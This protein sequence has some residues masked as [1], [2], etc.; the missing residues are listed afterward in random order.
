MPVLSP[1]GMLSDRK[2]PDPKP[3]E[4]TV[5]DYMGGAYVISD[6]TAQRF[7]RLGEGNLRRDFKDLRQISITPIA[8][9]GLEAFCVERWRNG[10]IVSTADGRKPVASYGIGTM[11]YVAPDFRGR[12]ICARLHVHRDLTEGRIA[13]TSYS[14][15]GF[16]ARLRAH[17]LHIEAALARGEY[18]PAV[19]RNQYGPADEGL[20][21]NTPYTPEDHNARIADLS[22]R[23]ARQRFHD[24]T[25]SYV[26][27]YIDMD[28]FRAGFA[29]RMG[30]GRAAGSAFAVRLAAAID[31]DIRVSRVDGLLCLQVEKDGLVHDVMGVRSQSQAHSD[32]MRREILFESD[33]EPE[34][35]IFRHPDEIHDRSLRKEIEGLVRAGQEGCTNEAHEIEA[36]LDRAQAF[37]EGLT[38]S[39]EKDE[40]LDFG[41]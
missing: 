31:G 28:R 17:A 25:D 41:A 4:Q 1:K 33:P 35:F 24:I 36:I 39:R 30:P 22:E 19:V 40:V 5:E 9:P 38:A 7:T 16:A 8:V 11:P 26:E 32:L 20:R 3:W 6:T 15:G 10:Y 23:R 13:A 29:G 14:R 12:G 34:V 37:D 27:R 21:L 18:V 2:A